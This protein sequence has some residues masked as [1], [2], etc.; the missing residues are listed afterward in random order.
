VP[1]APSHLVRVRR[2]VSGSRRVTVSSPA[3]GPRARGRLAARA[4]GR[5]VTV[6]LNT[7]LISCRRDV[8]D[9]ERRRGPGPPARA[10]RARAKHP[11]PSHQVESEPANEAANLSQALELETLALEAGPGDHGR[12]PPPGPA[13]IR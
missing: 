3:P 1:Q 10:A 4:A 11:R 6:P 2:G 5:T 9:R 7:D 12:P 8:A 13:V